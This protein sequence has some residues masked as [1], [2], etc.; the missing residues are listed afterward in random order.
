MGDLVLSKLLRQ[1]SSYNHLM[2]SGLVIQN[3]NQS[4]IRIDKFDTICQKRMFLRYTPIMFFLISSESELV[5]LELMT[6]NEEVFE[7]VDFAVESSEDLFDFVV[8]KFKNVNY[9]NCSGVKK[10]NIRPEKLP[11]YRN[12]EDTL[13]EKYGSNFIYRSTNCKRI[14]ENEAS[15]DLCDICKTWLLQKE[16]DLEETTLEDSNLEDPGF[17]DSNLDELAEV[18]I[19]YEDPDSDNEAVIETEKPHNKRSPAWQHFTTLGFENTAE[20]IYCQKL[21]P[22]FN[23]TSG[24]LKHLQ[25]HHKDVWSEINFKKHAD[26][27]V[28]AEGFVLNTKKLKKK[29]SLVW[30]HFHESTTMPDTAECNICLTQ[31][32][33]KNGNTT[34]MWLHMK[35]MHQQVDLKN[36]KTEDPPAPEVDCNEDESFKYASDEGHGLDDC[37]DPM[38]VLDVKHEIHGN[39]TPTDNSSLAVPLTSPTKTRSLVWNYFKKSIPAMAVCDLCGKD[40]CTVGNNTSGMIKHL[41]CMHPEIGFKQMLLQEKLVK[42]A[43]KELEKQ[44]YQSQ[45]PPA[46]YPKSSPAWKYFKQ[47]EL[48]R[49]VS[50]CNLC[51]AEISCVRRN[52]SGMLKH[53]LRWH[54]DTEIVM[55]K[56]QECNQCQRKFFFKNTLI[57]HLKVD[58]GTEY[59]K[60]K[61]TEDGCEM[62]FRLFKGKLMRRHLREVHGQEFNQ[63]EGMFLCDQCEKKFKSYDVLQKHIKGVHESVH[64]PCYI[65]AKLVKEGTPMEHHIKYVHLQPNKFQ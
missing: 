38:D 16:S 22:T 18:K 15:M 4:S 64:V 43:K 50:I 45:P 7:I 55:N 6:Y 65:C 30:Q 3:V 34:G 63:K 28:K 59:K 57:K 10:S 5:K 47:S 48:D 40:I 54:P 26:R 29:K 24:L 42:A 46:S 49:E 39:D 13:Y 35:R 61:C 37:I 33:C 51:N 56:K 31:I 14:I 12:D 41:N 32:A 58:H 44:E 52:T 27:A 9:S 62:Y 23:N 19:K 1:L 2:N 25:R 60:F 20:C 21:V 8:D 17:D 11:R 53:L 36:M